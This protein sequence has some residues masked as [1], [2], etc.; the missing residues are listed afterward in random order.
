MA[1][2]GHLWLMQI[3]MPTDSPENYPW[4]S[5]EVAAGSFCKAARSEPAAQPR[6]TSRLQIWPV[7]SF[8]M[9]AEKLEG[10]FE[11][12]HSA[13]SSGDHRS[14]YIPACLAIQTGRHFRHRG[15]YSDKLLHSCLYLTCCSNTV[16]KD[17][18]QNAAIRKFSWRTSS[19]L[20]T[21][22]FNTI[23]NFLL[24]CYKTSIKKLIKR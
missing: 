21:Q 14:W 3:R 24:D 16:W 13:Q 7:L 23:K 4:S 10:N 6:R 8:L 20:S 15:C 12:E 1:F 18:C 11:S 2:Q 22:K 19:F 17:T 5:R 9:Q